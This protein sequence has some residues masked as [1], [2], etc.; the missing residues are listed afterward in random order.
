[1][2]RTHAIR[3]VALSLFVAASAAAT[4]VFAQLSVNIN[5]G[6]PPAQFEVVP[7]V[8]PGYIWAPGYWARHDDQFI[9]VR[10][11]S[12]VQRSGYRW[13]PDRWEQRGPAYY[14]HVGSWERDDHFKTPK[15][16]KEKKSKHDDEDRGRGGKHDR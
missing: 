10:G 3:I 2:K 4:P 12:I 6:P 1:M 14:R 16:K 5:I 8:A 7:Q 9:W 15:M 11:R 13:E